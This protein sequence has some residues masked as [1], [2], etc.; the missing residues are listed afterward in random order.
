MKVAQMD[1]S[2]TSSGPGDAD[3]RPGRRYAPNQPGDGVLDRPEEHSFSDLFLK[4]LLAQLIYYLENR[5]R[6]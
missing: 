3:V 2:P 5:E 4:F 1:S 6:A